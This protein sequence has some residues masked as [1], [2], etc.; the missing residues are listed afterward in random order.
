MQ[1]KS[2]FSFLNKYEKFVFLFCYPKKSPRNVWEKAGSYPLLENVA[3]N[4]QLSHIPE[5]ST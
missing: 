5:Y 3:R 1:K 4:S 2:V